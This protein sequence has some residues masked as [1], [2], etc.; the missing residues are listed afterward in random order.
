[1]ILSYSI[2]TLSLILCQNRCRITIK[3][4]KTDCLPIHNWQWNVWEAVNK[5]RKTG[6]TPSQ[7]KQVLWPV[8]PIETARSRPASNCSRRKQRTFNVGHGVTTWDPRCL[9]CVCYQHQTSRSERLPSSSRSVKVRC[10][11]YTT[12][13]LSNTGLVFRCA[14][15]GIKF[16]DRRT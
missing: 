12:I 13:L 3:L 7:N 9:P 2:I 10:T 4:T 1:M 11:I 16:I 15:R 6:A 14:I 5:W 8:Q